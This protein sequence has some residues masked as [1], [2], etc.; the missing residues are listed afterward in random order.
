MWTAEF[1]TMMS[2]RDE[3]RDGEL[4]WSKAREKLD[5]MR[6]EHDARAEELLDGSQYAEYTAARE[7]MGPGGR[8][9]GRRPG[10]G[11]NPSPE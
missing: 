9:G 10:D 1:E 6:G 11:R 3:V 7:Q 4:E 8:R 5:E 2:I